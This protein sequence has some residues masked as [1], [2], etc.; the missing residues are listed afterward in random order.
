MN[1]FLGLNDNM[2]AKMKASS[3]LSPLLVDPLPAP[4]LEQVRL[5][6][7][8]QFPGSFYFEI[9]LFIVPIFLIK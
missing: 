1:K 6:S 9:V 5:L 4:V 8:I 2:D 7:V 3:E